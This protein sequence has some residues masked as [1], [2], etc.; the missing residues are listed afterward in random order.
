MKSSSAESAMRKIRCKNR[1]AVC[2]GGICEAI[3]KVDSNIRIMSGS[4]TT[5]DCLL[6]KY[7][8]KRSKTNQK[9]AKTFK[10]EQKRTIRLKTFKK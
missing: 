8:Q 7:V 10:N 1:N 3:E 9:R 5:L 6:H 2:L 4:E